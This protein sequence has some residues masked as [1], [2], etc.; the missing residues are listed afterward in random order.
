MLFSS[1]PRGTG[2]RTQDA[3]NV[4][5]RQ[6]PFEHMIQKREFENEKKKKK[7]RIQLRNETIYA[8]RKMRMQEKIWLEVI[9]RWLYKV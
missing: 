3:E 4:E 8:S 1:L 6:R 2:S 5:I 9:R 7:V